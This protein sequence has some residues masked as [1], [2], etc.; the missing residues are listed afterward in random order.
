MCEQ[1]VLTDC[2]P[3]CLRDQGVVAE[4]QNSSRRAVLRKKILG[5]VDLFGLIRLELVGDHATQATR[6]LVCPCFLGMPL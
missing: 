6:R 5:P 1:C 2:T 4:G 3:E